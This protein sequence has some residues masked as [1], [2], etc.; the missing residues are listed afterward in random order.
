M[1]INNNIY[2]LFIG[3]VIS[4]VQSPA[5]MG[6][7]ASGKVRA[8]S[9]VVDPSPTHLL[10]SFSEAQLAPTSLLLVETLPTHQGE[11]F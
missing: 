9:H 3:S 4:F 5:Q 11:I 6:E 8:G 2:G 10:Q 1:G 7:Q